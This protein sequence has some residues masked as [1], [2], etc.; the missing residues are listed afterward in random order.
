MLLLAS[1]TSV[2][3][4]NLP[5]YAVNLDLGTYAMWNTYGVTGV[6]D[7]KIFNRP[8]QLPKNFPYNANIY[9]GY[10]GILLIMGLDITTGSYAPVAYDA[11]CPNCRKADT[12]VSIETTNYEAVCPTCDSHFNVLTGSGGPVSGKA[13]E[14]KIGMTLYK[15]RASANGG[16]VV[17]SR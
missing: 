4:D 3:N 15:V 11:A 5:S 12:M 2:D 14:R 7:Y 17:S 6:G 16:Y 13:F 9:T 1:C 8:K 10:G